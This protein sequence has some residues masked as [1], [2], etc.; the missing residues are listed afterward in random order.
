MKRPH[1]ATFPGKLVRI[2]L[3]DK[4]RSVIIDRFLS[5]S[6]RFVR[7]RHYKERQAPEATTGAATR[8]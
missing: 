4:A 7:L 5:R 2:V 6:D 8:E 1:T 3:K